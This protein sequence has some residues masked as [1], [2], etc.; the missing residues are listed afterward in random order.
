MQ[1][2]VGGMLKCEDTSPALLGALGRVQAENGAKKEEPPSTGDSQRIKATADLLRRQL[3]QQKPSLLKG[4]KRSLSPSSLRK[5]KATAIVSKLLDQDRFRRFKLQNKRDG[6]LLDK[7][8]KRARLIT[9][10]TL[11]KRHKDLLKA[12][13][14]HQTEFYKFH[15]GKKNE[16]GKI[17]RAIRDKLKKDDLQKEK[18]ADQAERARIAA[19]RA[20][21]MS[22]YTS[23][24]EETKNDRLK[25]LLDKT[26]ECMNQIS[27]LLQSRA[28]EEENDIKAMGGEGKIKAKF[29]AVNATAGS[30]YDTAHV[31][32]SEQIRQPS[33]LTG[34]DLKEY[35]LSGLQWLVSLY[36]NRLNGIL[37]DE[38]GL[39]KTIQTISLIAYLI[40]VKENLGPYLVIVP[41]STLSNW[42]NEFAKW[43]PAATV[44]C[45]KG[46][47]Q[48][49]KQ[50]FRDEVADG[51]FNVLLTTYEFVIR[52]K[53]SLRKLAWQYAIVDEGH[54]MKNNQSK[55]AVTLGTHYNTRRRVLLTG[56]PLQNSLPELWALLNFLLPAIFNSAETFDEWFNK[57]FASFGKSGN[58]AVDSGD[59]SSDE[60]LS[61]EERMLIIHRLHELLRPFMLRRVKSE[62]LD[63]L[64]EKVE[65]VIRCDLSS[66]QK[67]LYKQI[68]HKIAGEAASSKN[69]NRG[70]NNV[71][72]QLRKVCNHP[73]LFNKDGYHINDD[74]I[75]TSGK[76]ELLDRML[77]KLK[78]AGHRILMFTQMTKMMPILE[79]YFAYRGF[80]SLRLDGSTS[81]DEREKRMYMYNAPDSPYFIFLLS[82]RA[83]GLGLNLATADTVIIFDSDWNPMMDLQ[84]QDRAHRIGQRKDVRVFRII[85]QT[86][87]EEKI[88]SRATEKLQMNELVVEAGKFDKSGQEQENSS[89]ERLKMM[90]LLLTDFDQNQI[91]QGNA[92]AEEDFEKSTDDGGADEEEEENTKDLLNE[93]I[94]SN[95]DDY[96]L[97]C[98]MD[99]E[100]TN[101]P[102]LYTDAESVPDWILYPSGKSDGTSMEVET[103]VPGQ[104]LPKRRAAT[105]DIVYDDGLTE[106]QFCRMMDKKTIA[107]EKER[108]KSKK[109]R[110]R[111]ALDASAILDDASGRKRAKTQD[112]SGR[113]LSPMADSVDRL[114]K[115]EFT[116][117]VNERLISI[118][119]SL[120]YFKE[121]GTGRK[122]SEIFLEKP[123]P[124]TY[125]DYYQL[126]DKPIGMNDILRK[127]RAKLY[128]SVSEFRD[129]WN[130]MF[131]NC[132]TYNGEGTWITNDANALKSELNRLMDK[133]KEV[134]SKMPLR[135]K[136]SLKGKKK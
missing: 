115:G 102:A 51:Q 88:L 96:K 107:E 73:Y 125:P 49:R 41:L 60:L 123:C 38:M 45:Y 118:T 1:S 119:K 40:E 23:L 4:S 46:S 87:V 3:I 106:N 6:K 57:P 25:F 34:G 71:V 93:M 48:Q 122:L 128:S 135:I 53:A 104:P 68:S 99:I 8:I 86:P 43:L 101:A 11:S 129:D 133:N 103:I 84:A 2:Y 7:H 112:E 75:R 117:E 27:S 95:D 116:P 69:F 47:P 80:S 70:L 62:V 124:T 114:D 50:I 20:N 44:V 52:D 98:K 5:K 134:Q 65:K 10:D 39:G 100:N 30:Y 78:A 64:P 121:K 33:I 97:Y 110:S 9:T 29:S 66:W 19:L 81:A 21:D 22:A 12:I 79:D 83:G 92:T 16:A 54:R 37:A 58:A 28:E 82:T 24:L 91:S 59:A 108:K 77:P 89:L 113:S 35:Q 31:I 42:V 18:E 61:N 131:K 126:I 36:N 85:T 120:I 132:V 14:S 63:Q 111:N 109:K 136:L 72:M 94:S 90:E 26:D 130:T 67:E 15:R 127:C 105:G 17:A 32:K 74:I 13:I 76:L 55:F 56:T